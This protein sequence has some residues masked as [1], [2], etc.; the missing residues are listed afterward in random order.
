MYDRRFFQSQLGRS[1]L[2]SITAMVA[3]NVYA[4]AQKAEAAPPAGQL[5]M[6]Q[7]S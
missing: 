2:A 1:A 7:V 3:L 4:F 5:P 6:V